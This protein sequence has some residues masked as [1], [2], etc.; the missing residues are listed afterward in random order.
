[1]GHGHLVLYM[2]SRLLAAVITRQREEEDA[3]H[4]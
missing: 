2:R 3:P 4:A 1:M